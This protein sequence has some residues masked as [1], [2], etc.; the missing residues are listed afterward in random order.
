MRKFLSKSATVAKWSVLG[1]VAAAALVACGGGSAEA[2]KVAAADVTV[3]VNPTTGAAATA[4]VSGQAFT[5]SSGVAEFGTTAATT[6]QVTS[7]VGT[8]PA[9]FE[10]KSGTGTATGD[11]TFGSCIFTIKVST[12][13]SVVVGTTII[14]NPCSYSVPTAGKTANGLVLDVTKKWVLGTS[15]ATIPVKLIINTDGSVLVDGKAFGTVTLSNVTG[16]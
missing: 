8:A 3:V 6:V 14:V 9:A 10:I 13:P 1:L 2:T 16:G 4:G 5:F 15:V 12:I 7:G 11:Y